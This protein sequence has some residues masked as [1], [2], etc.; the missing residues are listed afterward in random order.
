VYVVRAGKAEMREITILTESGSTGVVT[1][2]TAGDMVILNPPPGLLDGSV[3]KAL[4]APAE[5]Q[6]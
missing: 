5:G 2:V 1:G 3:V 6:K 4:P